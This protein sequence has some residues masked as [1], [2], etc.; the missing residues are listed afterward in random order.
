MEVV[1]KSY[2]DIC[3]RYADWLRARPRRR[4]VRFTT[5]SGIT[6]VFYWSKCVSGKKAGVAITFDDKGL[7]PILFPIT[8]TITTI[9]LREGY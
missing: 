6:G 8:K 2:L 5:Q 1:A 7:R 9:E 3:E 4:V